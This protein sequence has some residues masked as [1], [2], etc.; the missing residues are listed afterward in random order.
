[1]ARGKEP[2]K[3]DPRRVARLFGNAP[4]GVYARAARNLRVQQGLREPFG[5]G[6]VQS[7]RYRPMMEGAF[8]RQNL[9]GELFVLAAAESGFNPR[10]RSAA[11]AVEIW[12]FIGGLGFG[13]M[14]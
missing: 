9:P 5:E 3:A 14:A 2:T 8:Q 11:G 10:A 1:M 12:Q 4:R 13:Q 6:M 7:A